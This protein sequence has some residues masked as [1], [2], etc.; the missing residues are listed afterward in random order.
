MLIKSLRGLVLAGSLF[1]FQMP[2][3]H[4]E[5]I[6][7]SVTHSIIVSIIDRETDL[8]NEVII[9]LA[10]TIET[11][12]KKFKLHPALILAVIY[13]ESRFNI[14]AD[15]G[16]GTGLMQ[17][18]GSIHK[19]SKKVLLN[20]YMNVWIGSKILS[21]YASM[22]KSEAEMLQRYNGTYGVTDAYSQKVLNVKKK[23]DKEFNLHKA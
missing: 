20:P 2:V 13:T 15:V 4:T 19:K 16:N 23:F 9:G 7:Y 6:E 18:V 21:T 10:D 8:A 12:S 5:S 1:I 17:V 22:S 11:V 3:I 14:K